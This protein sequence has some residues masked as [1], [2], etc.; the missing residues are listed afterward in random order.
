MCT[1]R[2]PAT[3]GSSVAT[4]VPRPVVPSCIVMGDECTDDQ[5][6]WKKQSVP[7]SGMCTR[8]CINLQRQ[9]DTATWCKIG[10]DRN[11]EIIYFHLF[12]PISDLPDLIVQIHSHVFSS[13]FQHM[14][15]R[16][17]HSL[18]PCLCLPPSFP[19]SSAHFPAPACG[20]TS[21]KTLFSNTPSAKSPFTLR[22]AQ[23]LTINCCL[24]HPRSLLV[25]P[26]H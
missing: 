9:V 20:T 18:T 5:H 26:R 3:R 1:P 24:F 11:P 15:R 12:W 23:T 6:A 19:L 21:L 17:L 7:D 13:S 8:D 25:L 16:P 4:E 14:H 2:L 10:S 22:I